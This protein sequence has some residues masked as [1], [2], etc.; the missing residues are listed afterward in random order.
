M[1]D[2]TLMTR[3]VE[4]VPSDARLVLLG[5]HHQLASVDAAWRVAASGSDAIGEVTAARWDSSTLPTA[6]EAVEKDLPSLL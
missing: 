3:L 4:A 6:S 5:D 2:L 1:L